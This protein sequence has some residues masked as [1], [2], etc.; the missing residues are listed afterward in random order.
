MSVYWKMI[1]SLLLFAAESAEACLTFSLQQDET[2]VYGRNFDWE[3]G[4]G[5][6]FVNQ[7]H[8]C[9]VAFVLPPEKPF[10]WI[11]KYGS[12][13][14]NQFSRE[15][16]IGG[17]N[18]KGLVIECL[19]SASKYPRSDQRKAVN[20]FQWIQYQLDSCGSV[21]E[22]IQSAQAMRIAPYALGLHYFITDASGV[23]AVIEYVGGK[24]ICYSGKTLPLKV[25]A[26]TS[27]AYALKT[28]NA[29]DD[30]FERCAQF[31]KKYDGSE[32]AVAFSFRALDSIA[33]GNFT[34]WQVVYDL[35]NQRISFRTTANRRIKQIGLSDFDFEN[36]TLLL[37]VNLD[38][39]GSVRKQF[40]PY[41][42]ERNNEVISAALAEF[43]K[44]GIMR[45]LTSDQVEVI[46]ATVGAC[47]RVEPL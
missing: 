24:L 39:E 12:V 38:A 15:V 18:E 8:V 46:K 10:F 7:R 45:Q 47:Y 11:S 30:R 17:M 16:P 23:S 19:V 40:K 44:A 22:V 32:D 42:E 5:A 13:T 29:K 27:Y 2:L 34:K 28:K 3:V 33:Q 14:F 9:K 4:E 36:D 20:E 6:V 25:L 31:L 26:N 35:P 1:I 41:T 21:A 37:D 43:K